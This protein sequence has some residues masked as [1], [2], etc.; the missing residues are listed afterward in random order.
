MGP[1]FNT[2]ANTYDQTFSNTLIGKAQ[3]DIVW[4]YLDKHLPAKS[5]SILEINCGTG[6]DAIYLA[7]KG[8]SVLATDAS[9]EMIQIVEQKISTNNLS[10]KIETGVWD[11]NNPFPFANKKFDLIFSNFGGLNCLSPDSINK[12]SKSCT[13]LLNENGKLIFVVMGRFCLMETIYFLLKGKFKS[14]FRRSSKKPVQAKLGGDA[15]IDIWY[16]KPSEL[17]KNFSGD[18]KYIRKRPVGLFVPPS[19]ME[20][21]M[22][23]NKWLFSFLLFW[24]RLFRS[25]SFLSGLSDHFLIEFN[26][27]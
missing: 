26:K 19:Y 4:E 3:R 9:T 15:M 1:E 11:L 23:N 22:K 27:K 10:N 8:H 16:Y 5:I 13:E 25:V 2:I 7:G 18:F 24:D 21:I 14:A 17:R 6:E 20:R 12:L